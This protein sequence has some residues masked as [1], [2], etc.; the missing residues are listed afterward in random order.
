VALD[1]EVYGHLRR[2]RPK[3]LAATS[4]HGY[5]VVG[6]RY[7]PVSLLR[8]IHSDQETSAKRQCSEAN[9]GKSV[10]KRR[11]MGKLSDFLSNPISGNLCLGYNK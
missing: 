11:Q 3:I 1:D 2:Y 4:S 6:F 8:L 10:H 9:P 7:F 5:S